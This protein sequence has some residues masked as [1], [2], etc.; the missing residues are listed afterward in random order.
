[1]DD[2]RSPAFA[3]ELPDAEVEAVHV[4]TGTFPA[5]Y[6]RKLGGVVDVTTSKDVRRGFHGT[7]ETGRA[8]SGPARRSCREATAGAAAR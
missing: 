5:E 3:P 1:M 2:N 6:G 8:A 7:A 4:I